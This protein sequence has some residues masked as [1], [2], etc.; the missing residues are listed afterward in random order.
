MVCSY[1]RF[2]PGS[3]GKWGDLIYQD[4]W[5]RCRIDAY[6]GDFLANAVRTALPH[7]HSKNW[8]F[9]AIPDGWEPAPATISGHGGWEGEVPIPGEEE[10]GE[11]DDAA[12]KVVPAPSGGGGAAVPI[13]AA[14]RRVFLQRPSLD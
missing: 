5:R 13:D 9:E 14:P 2:V 1:A 4:P 11:L 3:A 8:D 7:G 12:D 6:E 10:S